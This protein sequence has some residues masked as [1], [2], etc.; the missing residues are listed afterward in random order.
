MSLHI[1]AYD[2][3]SYDVFPCNV[4]SYDVSYYDVFPCNVSFCNVSYDAY[5]DDVC[6]D[7]Y[8]DIYSN[9]VLVDHYNE[10]YLLSQNNQ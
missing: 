2:V 3:S 8:D 4:S 6:D 1:H 10:S 5:S 7:I 9:I